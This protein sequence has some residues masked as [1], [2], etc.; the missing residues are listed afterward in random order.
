MPVLEP[1]V[2]PLQPQQLP[3]PPSVANT[4]FADGAYSAGLAVADHQQPAHPQQQQYFMGPSGLESSLLPAVVGA[5]SAFDAGLHF[6]E[7]LAACPWPVPSFT[8]AL[9]GP[10]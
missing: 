9:V 3:L 10:A 2:M 4:T 5:T 7:G 8:T 1:S 6:G